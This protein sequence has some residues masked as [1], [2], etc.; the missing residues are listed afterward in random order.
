MSRRHL[1]LMSNTLQSQNKS[2]PLTIASQES[3]PLASAGLSTHAADGSEQRGQRSKPGT[4]HSEKLCQGKEGGVEILGEGR[5]LQVSRAGQDGTLSPPSGLLQGCCWCCTSRW[6]PHLV[7]RTL[8]AASLEQPR[9]EDAEAPVVVFP[10][11]EGPGAM[12][13]CCS[14]FPFPVPTEQSAARSC[15]LLEG[16]GCEGSCLLRGS[17]GP[18]LLMSRSRCFLS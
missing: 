7:P 15:L 16:K 6:A 2:C 4:V 3:Q 17:L 8:S 13:P 10:D 18:L 9:R 5:L 14:A 11:A 1:A 12:V